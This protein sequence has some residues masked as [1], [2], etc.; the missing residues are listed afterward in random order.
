M[1]RLLRISFSRPEKPRPFV[2][3]LSLGRLLAVGILLGLGL[4]LHGLVGLVL[5]LAGTDL[6]MSRQPLAPRPVC[7]PALG[8]TAVGMLLVD[9][10]VAFACGWLV[11]LV[12]DPVLTTWQ[13]ASGPG[14]P[15][16][17]WHQPTPPPLT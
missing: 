6:A 7:W 5:L 14:E 3:G 10:A 17:V 13:S 2:A 11:E 4:W 12:C 15:R 16:P 1:G 9:P 8:F